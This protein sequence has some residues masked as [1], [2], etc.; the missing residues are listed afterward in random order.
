MGCGGIFTEA[1]NLHSW[2]VS[3]LAGSNLTELHD[4]TLQTALFQAATLST[5]CLA[6]PIPFYT[7]VICLISFIFSLK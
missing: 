7:F 1:M 4:L 6:L 2:R 5:K 3:N